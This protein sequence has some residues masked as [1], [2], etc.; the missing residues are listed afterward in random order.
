M[1]AGRAAVKHFKATTSFPMTKSLQYK[2]LL[3]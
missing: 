3:L 1:F 2:F